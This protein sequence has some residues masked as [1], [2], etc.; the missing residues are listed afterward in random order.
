MSNLSELVAVRVMGAKVIS[1]L[2]HA[3]DGFYVRNGVACY[4]RDEDK[5]RYEWFCPDTSIAD[6]WRVV[7]KM[8]HNCM[9][10]YPHEH[11]DGAYVTAKTNN[12]DDVRAREETMP[13]AI[14]IAALR[15]CGVSEGEITQAK[16]DTP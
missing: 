5:R 7:E 13:L 11:E 16:K 10:L 4:G 12:W 14:C 2:D 9:V 8:K 3:P 1:T 6:A 15:A